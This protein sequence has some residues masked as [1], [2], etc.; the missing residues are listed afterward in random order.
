MLAV[1]MSLRDVMPALIA[2]YRERN[3]APAIDTTFGGSGNLRKQVH[4]GAPVDGVVFANAHTVDDLVASGHADPETRAVV[5]S[6]RLVL[7]GPPGGPKLRFET[8][9]TAPEG[10]RIAIGE[11]AAVPAG[12]YA[13]EAFEALRK[14]EAIE[15]RL[16]YGGHVAAVLQYARRG[17]VAAA[18]VYGTDIRNVDDV[19]VLDEA[20]GEWA[21]RAEVVVAAVDRGKASAEGRKFLRYLSSSEARE[22]FRRF[23]F[24]PP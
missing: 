9:D 7:I 11:P 24:G 17:E 12:R 1:A 16:V 10:E 21:P 22:I 3:G 6:N 14:W 5:A 8:I 19:V 18:V 4:A 13:K 15:D 23:G 20:E 2:D